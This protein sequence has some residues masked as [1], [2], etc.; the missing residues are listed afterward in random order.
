MGY[1]HHWTQARS[2]VADEWA[3]VAADVG[4]L[5]AYAETTTGVALANAM[6]DAGTRPAIAG[7][8]V[9]FNGAANNSHETF[10]ITRIRRR[11]W[12]GATPGYDSC[13]TARKPY[14]I[15]VTACLCYLS[16]VTGTHTVTSDGHAGDF[17][18]G[19]ELAKAALPEKANFLDL[20]IGVMQAD[21]W[22]GPWISGQDE[23]GYRVHFCIDGF[24]YVERLEPHGWYRFDTHL[25]LARFLDVNK[26]AK[27]P[28]GGDLRWGSYP[29]TEA[30]IWSASGAFDE[31]RHKRIAQAQ[32]RVLAGLFPAPAH[33]AHR[34]P[35]FVR[36][37]DYPRPED[38]GTFC[39]YVR[40]V[41]TRDGQPT[42]APV[43]ASDPAHII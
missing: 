20:P 5:L 15:V 21:R 13:K 42:A 19:L 25:A 11:A 17:Q 8:H 37:G 40:D 4:A 9:A 24:G 10:T 6:G 38:N 23:S 31:Q 43:A 36:P 35:A 34:P 3:E 14:D 7:R 26:A 12:K 16:S 33:N 28:N 30:D 41:L 29:A 32:I 1:T 27:F 2:F 18:A 39:Y 22:T